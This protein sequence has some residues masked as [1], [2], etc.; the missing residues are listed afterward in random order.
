MDEQALTAL[1]KQEVLTWFSS[2]ENQSDGYEYEKTF[3]KCWQ[4]IGQKVLQQSMGKLPG[5]KNKKKN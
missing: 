4:S 5:S 2:Q 1:V 3:V